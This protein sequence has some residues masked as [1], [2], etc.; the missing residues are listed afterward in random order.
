MLFI[1]MEDFWNQVSSTPRLSRT[2]E[3]LLAQQASAGNRAA[4]EALVRGYLP[5]AAAFIRRAPQELHTLRTV[6]ACIAAVE[7]SVDLLTSPQDRMAF[8]NHLNRNLRQCITRCLAGR[9]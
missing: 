4:R 7:K 6:Y 2:E 1:S 5:M 9:Y 8:L 3:Q